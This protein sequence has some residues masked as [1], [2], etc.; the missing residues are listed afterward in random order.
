MSRIEEV[1]AK[2]KEKIQGAKGAWIRIKQF[3]SR[4]NK[5]QCCAC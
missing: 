2:I 4:N 5:R 3:P 1:K